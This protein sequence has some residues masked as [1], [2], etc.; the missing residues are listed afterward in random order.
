VLEAT[1]SKCDGTKENFF[2]EVERVFDEF[3]KYHTKNEP[4][5]L[6]GIALDYGLDDRCSERGRGWEFFSLTPCADRL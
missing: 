6:S 5:Y 1:E 3:P 4:G 2:K